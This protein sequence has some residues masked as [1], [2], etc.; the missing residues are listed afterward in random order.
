M[1]N[2]DTMSLTMNFRRYNA[3]GLDW[4]Y[5]NRIHKK[6]TSKLV[7]YKKDKQNK[8][9]QKKFR[10][11]S[12]DLDDNAVDKVI[13]NRKRR[14][15]VY[16]HG[17]YNGYIFTYNYNWQSLTVMLS[18]F[19]VEDKTAEQIKAEVASTIVDYFELEPDELNE[20]VVNRI[21]IHS[22]Y[23]YDDKD[24][25]DIIINILDKAPNTYYTYKK[26]LLKNDNNGYML[27]YYSVKKNNEIIEP[28]TISTGYKAFEKGDGK[29]D[30]KVK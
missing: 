20:L 14:F 19:K 26:H 3:Y 29:K 4:E 30:E 25:I 23:K 16:Y 27:K 9:E 15:P 11:F 24:E 17:K 10:Y 18:N 28:I 13:P 2:V 7:L 12:R 5:I 8:Q 6:I 1:Y 22:D 21:D